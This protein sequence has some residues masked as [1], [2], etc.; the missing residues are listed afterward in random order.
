MPFSLSLLTHFPNKTIIISGL[1]LCAFR[2]RAGPP[3]IGQIVAHDDTPIPYVTVYNK[4]DDSWLMSDENGHIYFSN[5]HQPGDT[6]EF[7]RI[8]FQNA[9]AA[10]PDSVG[11]FQIRLHY[12][13]VTIS[14]VEISGWLPQAEPRE[15]LARIQVPREMGNVEPDQVFSA[16]PGIY[17]RSYGGPAG[18]TTLSLDGAPASHTNIYY[19]GFDLTS[20][21][22][23]QMDISQLPSAFIGAIE[24]LPHP[25]QANPEAGN[26]EGSIQI[27]PEESETGFSAGFGSFGYRSLTGRFALRTA[28]TRAHFTLGKRHD[29]AD[30]TTINP[31]ND[32]PLKRKNNTFDQQYLTSTVTT[33]FSPNLFWKTIVMDSRQE[34]GVA[35]LVWSPTPHAQRDDRLTMFGSKLGWVNR[36][37]HGYSHFLI[38]RNTDRYVNPQ[39]SINAEHTLS[40]YQLLV[41]Q[42]GRLGRHVQLALITDVR[43]D[44]LRSTNTASHDRISNKTIAALTFTPVERF[45]F[46]PMIV[47]DYSPNLFS[48]TNHDLQIRWRFP[49]QKGLIYTTA[50]KF[51]RHPTFND[52]YWKPGGNPDLQPEQTVRIAGGFSLTGFAGCTFKTHVYYKESKNLI[53]WTPIQSYW[54]PKNIEKAVRKGYKITLAWQH[55]KIPV[56]LNAGYNYAISRNLTPGDYYQK[57]LRYAPR[58]TGSLAL[59]WHPGRFFISLQMVHVS[60]RLAMYNW[61]EDLRL[62]PYTV[63]AL[64]LSQ[65][66]KCRLGSFI[67]AGAVNNLG[68]RA[69]ETLLGYP[70]PPRSLRITLHYEIN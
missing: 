10:I 5:R 37:G 1:L 46:S 48:T 64:N 42:A 9:I 13:P 53:L 69:Y 15:S 58:E 18:I 67:I 25:N 32:I 65:R 43:Y 38:K 8:G 27:Q 26:A 59:S 22:N 56:M 57:P 61:P 20:A 28:K 50:G 55:P 4:S 11:F 23:G 36:I 31:V 51:Y 30:Y 14:S 47:H 63:F 19:A 39:N 62:K 2:L 6:L 45:S 40:T 12:A 52:L 66:L 54:Q 29:D 21:Q 34:R 17:L 24:Y 7:R 35:G 49:D 60:S 33:V 3:I 70:E 16:I 41:R 68:D 44:Y